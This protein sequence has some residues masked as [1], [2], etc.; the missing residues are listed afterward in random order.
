MRV[1]SLSS[2][3]IEGARGGEGERD[4]REREGQGQA[5]WVGGGRETLGLISANPQRLPIGGQF[6]EILGL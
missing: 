4:E 1:S 5:N 3:R 2:R 6:S